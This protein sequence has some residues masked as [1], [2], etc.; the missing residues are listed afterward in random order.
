MNQFLAQPALIYGIKLEGG[1][2]AI[3]RLDLDCRPLKRLVDMGLDSKVLEKESQ[4]GQGGDPPPGGTRSGQ[5]AGT[6]RHGLVNSAFDETSK[7]FTGPLQ[8]PL[9]P[10][11]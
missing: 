9:P 7:G 2:V 3:I 4:Q 10:S 5:K 1:L 8:L 11:L 6:A